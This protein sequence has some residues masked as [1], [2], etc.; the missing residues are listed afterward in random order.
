MFTPMR[1]CRSSGASSEWMAG[2]TDEKI[3]ATYNNFYEFGS[4][5]TIARQAQALKL[6]PWT[7]KLSR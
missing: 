7:V 5:K 4:S 6:R 1:S 3:N 2:V